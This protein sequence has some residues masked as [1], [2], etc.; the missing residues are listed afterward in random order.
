MKAVLSVYL[1]F[2]IACASITYGIK[3]TTSVKNVIDSPVK[4]ND[5]AV[6][7]TVNATPPP[8][9]VS[10]KAIMPINATSAKGTVFAGIT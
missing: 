8:Q 10:L 5:N 4:T 1:N 9:P 3:R 6:T 7:T 2:L